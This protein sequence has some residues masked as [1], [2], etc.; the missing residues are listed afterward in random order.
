[1]GIVGGECRNRMEIVG[2]P[3]VI[4]V[5]RVEW[6]LCIIII[7]IIVVVVRRISCGYIMVGNDCIGM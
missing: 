3:I 5:R 2:A 1:M 4:I 6:F 7:I